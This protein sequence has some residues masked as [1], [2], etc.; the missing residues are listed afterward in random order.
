MFC[1]RLKVTRKNITSG[2]KDFPC[3][4]FCSIWIIPNMFFIS[5]FSFSP[6]V[7]DRVRTKM[8]RDIL[9][10]VNHPFIVKLHYGWYCLF[11]CGSF[12]CFKA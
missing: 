11:G 2:N 6:A 3:A 5:L 12:R 8:E 9:V 10:E 1:G 7:R 4:N